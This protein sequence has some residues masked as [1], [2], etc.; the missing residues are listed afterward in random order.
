MNAYKRLTLEGFTTPVYAFGESI[1]DKYLDDE[2]AFSRELVDPTDRG[3]A[4]LISLLIIHNQDVS[5]LRAMLDDP[6]AFKFE[7]KFY[8]ELACAYLR[9]ML[10]NKAAQ[11][12]HIHL[13]KPSGARGVIKSVE[14]LFMPHHFQ[15]VKYDFE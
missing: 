13:R 4:T 12:C 7:M 8:I 2:K 5:R 10:P 14:A 15:G 6:K 3:C 11:Q 9:S 1:P